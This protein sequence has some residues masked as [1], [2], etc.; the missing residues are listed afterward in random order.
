M[1][2]KGVSKIDKKSSSSSAKKFLDLE[3]MFKEYIE[4]IPQYKELEE[5]G[6]LKDKRFYGDPR[7]NILSP[8]QVIEKIINTNYKNLFTTFDVFNYYNSTML[9]YDQINNSLLFLKTPS[10]LLYYVPYLVV[11]TKNDQILLLSFRDIDDFIGKSNLPFLYDD[12]VEHRVFDMPAKFFS[13][14]F[15]GEYLVWNIDEI[16]YISTINKYKKYYGNDFSLQSYAEFVKIAVTKIYD[17]VKSSLNFILG[18]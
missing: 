16:P 17:K 18:G 9:T 12:I 13:E 11:L 4:K 10:Y 3:G 6:V 15:G 14:S 5:W 2:L 8:Q 1:A 7:M